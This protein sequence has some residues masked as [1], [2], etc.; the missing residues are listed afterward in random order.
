MVWQIGQCFD[1]CMVQDVG[2]FTTLDGC[3]QFY[4]EEEANALCH[5]VNQDPTDN[6]CA[7]CVSANDHCMFQLYSQICFM[8]A[9]YWGDLELVAS[10]VNQC[11]KTL[12][13]NYFIS[14]KK[15]N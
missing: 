12:F 6:S 2:C 11:S 7:L 10:D 14:P 13:G 1:N 9:N 5:A 3:A 4:S 8:G 15:I